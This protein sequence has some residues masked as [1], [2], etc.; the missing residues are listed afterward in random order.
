MTHFS[1][2]A[3]W[4]STASLRCLRRASGRVAAL[5]FAGWLLAAC[6]P[7]QQDD[8]PGSRL[9]EA[10]VAADLASKGRHQAAAEAYLQLAGES[11]EPL[12][13]RYL[14][15]AARQRQL[16]G[17]IGGAQVILDSL[18]DPVADVNLL[19][20][21]QV[22][23]AL[24]IARNEPE[25]TLAVLSAAPE[26]DNAVAAA[27]LLRLRGEALFRLGDMQGATQAYVEREVWLANRADIASNQRMLWDGYRRFGPGVWAA[28][29]PQTAG[30]TDALIDGWLQLGYLAATRGSAGIGLSAGLT[31]WQQ[32][33]PTHPANKALLPELL[34]E[35]GADLSMP[36]RVALLVPLTGTYAASGSAIRDGLLAA[37]YSSP[38]SVARPQLRVYDTAGAGGVLAAAQAA[39]ADG[40][41]FLVGPL[42]KDS[43]QTLASAQLNGPP[44]LA[45]N[46]LTEDTQAPRNWYQF[47][48]AP[49]DEAVQIAEHAVSKGQTRAI[50]LVP[51]SAWGRRLL[52]SFSEH[53]QSLGGRLLDYRFFDPTSPDFSGGLQNVL[54][55]RESEAR[56]DRLAANLG[57][58]LSFEPRR[59][60]DVDLIFLA[61]SPKAGKLIRPQLRFY[62][63]GD[64]PTYATSSVFQQGSSNNSDL[65]GLLLADMPWLVAPDPETRRV[66]ATLRE[67]WPR[68]AGAL[69]R[70]YAMGFDAYRLLPELAA[71]RASRGE[72]LE[73]VTGRL[74]LGSDGRLHRR[75]RWAQITRGRPVALEEE[76]PFSP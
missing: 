58:S 36:Q 66:Q 39:R 20:W 56:R 42:L 76:V 72:E 47:A 22:A 48:L 12:R 33:Y 8:F 2:E 5:A 18:N 23:A 45:L 64:I 14:I 59:R 49:E 53:Y 43:L 1:L 17:Q 31:A 50:A 69:T 74:F 75:L 55:I 54:L 4:P 70:L 7:L 26:T 13:E 24:S 68:E 29:L 34:T 19:G 61:A 73:G 51:N 40:A 52:N 28:E 15:L 27:E 21:S 3:A 35:F 71:G 25:R 32:Q 10:R 38:P 62:Y 16:S 60:Q 41:D 65:N 6:A 63:A 67:R 44:A 57:V 11:D 30:A 9:P 46:Y 37:F